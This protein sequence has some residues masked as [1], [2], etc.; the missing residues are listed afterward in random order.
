MADLFSLYFIYNNIYICNSYAAS[1]WPP[2]LFLYITGLSSLYNSRSLSP[3]VLHI[4]IYI[5]IYIHM[6]RLCSGLLSAAS[7]AAG[8]LEDMG[9]RGREGGGGGGGVKTK[10]VRAKR[11]HRPTP[12][13]AGVDSMFRCDKVGT[14]GSGPRGGTVGSGPRGGKPGV[15]KASVFRAPPCGAAEEV[16]LLS[17]RY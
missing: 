3:S 17:I 16:L 4:Y 12:K 10:V 13:A 1:F 6:Q 7:A 8:A 14:L 2:R 5:Y 11:T 15:I 9:L